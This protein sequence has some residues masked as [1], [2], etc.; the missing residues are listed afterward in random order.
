MNI[1]III[2]N[3]AFASYLNNRL[4]KGF[5]NGKHSEYTQVIYEVPQRLVLGPILFFIIV[6]DLG[7]NV[8]CKTIM[9]ANDVTA[10]Y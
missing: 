5:I 4:Q 6:Y 8:D 2:E 1:I 9:F 3:S 7:V 10:S